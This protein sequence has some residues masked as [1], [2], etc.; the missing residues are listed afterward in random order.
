[1]AQGGIGQV[2]LLRNKLTKR[3]VWKHIAQERLTE[4]LHLN[5]AS[6]GVLAFGTLRQRVAWDLVVRPHYAYGVLKAADLAREAGQSRVAVLEFGVASGAGL[7]NLADL[8]RRVTAETGVE[9]E[10][11]GFDSGTGMPPPVD[12]RDHPDLYA[13]GDFPMDHEA[14]RAML[15]P[16]AH[17]H[18][19]PLSATV[20]ALLAQLGTATPIGFVALDVDYYSSSV[21]AL[22]VLD[23]P[24]ET[25]LPLVVLYADDI[26]L[27]QHNSAC[28]EL[29]AIEEFNAA[30]ASRR[31]EA[32]AFFENMRIFRRA[33]WVKQI[34]FAH[35]LDHPRRST[36]A[37][38]STS[39]YIENPY[40]KGEQ[41]RE[42]FVPQTERAVSR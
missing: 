5:L 28:G 12:H 31:I 24:A 33:G 6:L 27:E 40:L 11:H 7:L 41:R 38:P 2:A 18:L 4:P 36:P 21:E 30:H 29:L 34:L 26:N 23:G 17:L 15:P 13:E 42:L 9:V 19:G 10:V 8:A 14:L 1:M 32:H 25:Y 20:P 22:R 3:R 16:H 39:R 37:A 35:V